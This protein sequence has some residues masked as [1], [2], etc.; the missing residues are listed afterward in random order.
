MLRLTIEGIQ[1]AQAANN[2]M[3]AALKPRGAF[4]RA[5]Q[6]ALT[7]AHRFAVI[8]THVDTGALR[9]SQ[10]MRLNEAALYG[11]VYIDPAA[12]NPITGERT[13]I[14]GPYEHARG[15]EHAFYERVVNERGQQILGEAADVLVRGLP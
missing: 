4:G 15:G 2:Q 7:E 6:V 13:A 9:A 11:L 12:R 8:I 1:Q 5:L 14:Y 3:I 10:R